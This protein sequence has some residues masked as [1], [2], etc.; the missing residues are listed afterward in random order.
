MCV[1]QLLR[2]HYL[3]QV[4]RILGDKAPKQG[5]FNWDTIIK[6]VE[7]MFR[8]FDMLSKFGVDMGG[9]EEYTSMMASVAGL[10]NKQNAQR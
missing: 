9:M 3:F 8:N 10:L 4:N 2:N 5:I 7:S 1:D 6:Q